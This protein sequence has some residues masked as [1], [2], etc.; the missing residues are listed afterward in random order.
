MTRAEAL[1]A[2]VR[3]VE[4]ARALAEDVEF[5]AEDAGRSDPAFLHE[6]LAAAAEAGATTLNVPDTV[7]F[8]TPDEYHAMIAGVR[9]AVRDRAV[10]LSTHCHDDLG[11][12]VANSLAGVRAGA[13]QVECT[14][15]GLGERAGNAA[16]EEVVMALRT[17]AAL[18]GVSTGVETRELART[19]RL[20]ARCSGV[21]VPPNKAIVGANAFAHESG[22]HQDGVL[23]DRSTYEIMTPEAVGVDGSR[24]VLGKH[25]GR[26]AVRRRLETMGYV[27]GDDEFAAVFARFKEICDRKKDVDERDLEAVVASRGG[28]RAAAYTLAMVRASCGTHAEATATVGLRAPDGEV[29]FGSGHGDGPIDAVCRAIDGVTGG[30]ARL[31]EFAVDAITEGVDAAGGVH[32][33]IRERM[34][35]PPSGAVTGSDGGGDQAAFGRVFAGYGV[36]TDIVVAAGEAYVAA[37]NTLLDVRRAAPVPQ[38]ATRAPRA[39]P[40]VSPSPSGPHDQRG[41]DRAPAGAHAV[42]QAV[43]RARRAPGDR[44][45]AGGALRGPAPRARGDVAAGVRR[46][47]PARARG[48]P[49]RPDARD[50]GPLHLHR[51]AR[52]GAPVLADGAAAQL[53][54]LEENCAEF[55]VP[56][57]AMGSDRRGIVHVVGP[58]LG[59]TQPGMTVVCGDSHT[60]THGAFGA[61]AFGIGTSEVAQ[62]LATQCLLQRRSRTMEVRVDGRLAPGVTA[63]DVILAVVA[64]IGVAG[65]TGHVLEYTGSAVRA[66]DVEARMTVCNMSIETGARA[67]LVAPDDTTLEYLAGRPHAPA[68][69]AWDSA[70]ARWRGLATD[71]DAAYDSA[72]SLDGSAIAPMISY[73]TNPGMSIPIDGRVP[74]PR[75]APDA[76]ERAA[77]EQALRY[78]AL[79]PGQPLAG[80]AVDVVFVGS[81]TNARLSDLRDVAGVLRGRRV[82]PG[83]ACSSSPAPRR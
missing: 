45:R 60:S 16:L 25:S 42:R 77:L 67:G 70:V 53:A 28:G 3:A 68:G 2:A 23:K 12:A 64:R 29:V 34:D 79:E 73:G 52:R 8:T 80:R 10:V 1:A 51:A 56:L 15:N 41:L 47:A 40:S 43:G 69:A 50:H 81:C 63:K 35:G 20:V 49:S 76:R 54:R 7:G 36:H 19:S 48:A 57:L 17:R 82:A 71:G 62:V 33:R 13:R 59:L 27:L 61:L 38:A 11:L 4:C 31:E 24:L 55:G 14:V 9:A 72:V 5:S 26:H 39:T 32:L 46:A 75:D 30:V 74:D 78:M 65:G 44:R 6:V 83:S 66:L 58:E 22:I 21:R 18:F 37:I